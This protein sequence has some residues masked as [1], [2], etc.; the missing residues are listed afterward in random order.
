MY[1]I[2]QKHAIRVNNEANLE[3]LQRLIKINDICK[4]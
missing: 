3:F 2:I 1:Q 4:G